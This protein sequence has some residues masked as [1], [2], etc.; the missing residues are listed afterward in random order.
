[1][2]TGTENTSS[3][4]LA[5]KALFVTAFLVAAV[6]TYYLSL[7]FRHWF[8]AT[9]PA[10]DHFSIHAVVGLILAAPVFFAEDRILNRLTKRD[11]FSSIRPV[12]IGVVV[13][14]AVPYAFP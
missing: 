13:G 8:V 2:E 11:V 7:P 12:T 1:M 6:G 4:S 3:E 9:Y 14:Y 10:L 5:S